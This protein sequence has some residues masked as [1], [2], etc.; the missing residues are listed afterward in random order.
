MSAGPGPSRSD[1]QGDSHWDRGVVP[2][3]SSEAPSDEP[4]PITVTHIDPTE[5]F[6]NKRA[7]LY[8]HCWTSWSGQLLKS[9]VKPMG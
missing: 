6:G 2:P 5:Q 3:V 4:L 8:L 1:S 9:W 7:A